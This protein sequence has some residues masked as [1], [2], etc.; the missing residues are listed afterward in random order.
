MD[1]V[2]QGR[3]ILLAV[4]ALSCAFGLFVKT[5]IVYGEFKTYSLIYFTNLSNIYCLIVCVFQLLWSALADNA[6]FI[7]IKGAAMICMIITGLVFV[8]LLNP[9]G[10]KMGGSTGIEYLASILLHYVA[11]LLIFAEWLLFEKK[12]V[13]SL[14]EP[15]IWVAIPIVYWGLTVFVAK[16]GAFIPNQNTRYPYNFIAVDL[17]GWSAVIRNVVIMAVCF[18]LLGY[19]VVAL[20]RLFLH[21]KLK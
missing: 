10:F 13:F 18:I 16:K 20:D 15:I 11:P 12:G 4:I 3:C 6:N 7:R 2:L 5:G 21:Y 9:G 17:Y 1:F 19:A 14:W 8:F